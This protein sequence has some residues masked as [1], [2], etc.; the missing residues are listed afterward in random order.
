MRRGCFP[1]SSPFDRSGFLNKELARDTAEEQLQEL[2]AGNQCEN[3]HGP[4]SRHVEL[5]E[6]G[7]IEESRQ[8]VRVSLEQA[9]DQDCIKCHDG[10]NSPGFKF[11]EY[12]DAVRHPG[13]D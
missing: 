4:G 13:M 9:R 6:A 7:K 11:E 5:V 2:L 10:D 3:C 12:W 8:D 1:R